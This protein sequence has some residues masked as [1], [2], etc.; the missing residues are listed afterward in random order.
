MAELSVEEL[1][2]LFGSRVSN[3][4]D[5]RT[6]LRE[7]VDTDN[8]ALLAFLAAYYD[9]C[10]SV[11]YRLISE[12]VT[13]RNKREV[14]FFLSVPIQWHI[15]LELIAAFFLGRSANT[16]KSYQ[17]YS[18]TLL[19][20]PYFTIENEI[21]EF[22][23]QVI[24]DTGWRTGSAQSAFRILTDHLERKLSEKRLLVWLDPYNSPRHHNPKNWIL[25]A[26]REGS[27]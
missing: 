19:L 13:A 5:Y 25:P 16:V 22:L 10:T 27:Y 24:A 26:P 8:R 7:A 21:E 3:P 23:K 12:S 1:Q 9:N 2:Q 20:E 15:Y 4:E 18:F 6:A 14:C 11:I 17:H